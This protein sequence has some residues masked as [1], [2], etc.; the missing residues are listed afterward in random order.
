VRVHWWAKAVVVKKGVPARSLLL[1]D[2]MKLTTA[3]IA[4]HN[5]YWWD[6]SRELTGMRLTR[7]LAKGAV[8]FS[9]HIKTPSMIKR[10][11]LVQ[12]VLDAGRIHIRSEGK[13]MRN[14]KRGERIMVKNLRN[15]EVIQAIAESA[16][17]VRVSLRENQG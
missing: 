12:I 4:G 7:P 3:D 10:G 14:A 16:G 6:N 5:G 11:D 2:M 15:N 17:V 13:A 1:K 9:S 8:I